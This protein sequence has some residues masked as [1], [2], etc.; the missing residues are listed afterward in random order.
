MSL[1]ERLIYS[2]LTPDA[3]K[4]WLPILAMG[5]V[6]LVRAVAKDRAAKVLDAVDVAVTHAYH[7]TNEY[8]MRRRA[9]GDPQNGA[10]DKTTFA[11]GLLAEQLRLAINRDPTPAEK[12]KA[13]IA[14]DA[15]HAQERLQRELG[16]PMADLKPVRASA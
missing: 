4:V 16:A 8:V 1:T 2:L 13:K 9:A 10:T 12:A 15:M 3:V 7:A 11:L 14:W 6:A 5:F